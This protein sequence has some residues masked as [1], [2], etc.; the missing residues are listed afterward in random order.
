[1]H[2]LSFVELY[3]NI[4]KVPSISAFDENLDQS[5]RVIIDLLSL[6]AKITTFV[7]FQSL[8]P[9]LFATDYYLGNI[10]LLIPIYRFCTT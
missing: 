10:A 1:M 5:N 8:L 3:E 7:M 4:I 9:L 6:S 2:K